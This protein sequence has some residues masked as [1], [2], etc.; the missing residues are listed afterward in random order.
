MRSNGR[1]SVFIFGFVLFG[2]LEFFLGPLLDPILVAFPAYLSLALLAL[3]LIVRALEPFARK[4]GWG[5]EGRLTRY[6]NRPRVIDDSKRLRVV[7]DAR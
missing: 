4:R 2:A 7:P 1:L 5:S 3:C 6:L